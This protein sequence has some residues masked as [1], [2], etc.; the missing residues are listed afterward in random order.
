M[1]LKDFNMVTGCGDHDRVVTRYG[2]ICYIGCFKGA[3]EEAIEAIKDKYRGSAKDAYISKINEL[4]DTD[5]TSYKK[6]GIDITADDNL[7][8]QWAS[9]NGYLNIVKYLVSQGADVTANNNFAI[10][11]ASISGH[12]KIV[13]YLVSQGADITAN[14]NDAVQ[15]A[16]KN[17]HLEIVNYLV[18]HGVTLD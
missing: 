8:I 2:D 6:R 14:D 16:S 10:Q 1:K 13:K 18:K 3:R 9:N 15:W 4:Y 11:W 12:L 17:G 5:I 7:A